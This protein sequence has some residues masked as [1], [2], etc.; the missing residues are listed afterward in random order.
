MVDMPEKI[1]EFTLNY[2]NKFEI[3]VDGSTDLAKISEA[4]FAVLAAG[5]N[6]ATPADNE[7]VTNDSYYDGE[8]FGGADVTAKRLQLTLAG[9]RLEGNK[10][11]DYIATKQLEV[12]DGLK[13]L[14]RWTQPNGDTITGLVTLTNIVTSGGAPGAKQTFSVVVVFNGKPTFTAASETSK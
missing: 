7:T 2:K 10:A 11:Q 1:G 3:A 5:I 12:G 14:F 8:G 13:T 6:N 4:E 9:H